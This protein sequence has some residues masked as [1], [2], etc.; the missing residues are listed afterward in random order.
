MIDMKLSV[1]FERMA[2]WDTVKVKDAF[3]FLQ[4]G[5][6]PITE[7]GFTPEKLVSDV[8]LLIL[9]GLSTRYLVYNVH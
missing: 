8:S 2:K 6:D 9:G 4:R 5:R 7:S 3:H 1:A